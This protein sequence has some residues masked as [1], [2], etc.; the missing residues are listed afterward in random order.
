VNVSSF[1]CYQLSLVFLG[2]LRKFG[3]R[4]PA[5]TRFDSNEQYFQQRVAE[6]SQYRAL[7]KPFVSFE[8]KTVLDMGCNRGYLLHSFL[9]HEKFEAIGADLVPYYLKDARR[10]YGDTIKF[11]QTTPTTI[12]LADNSVDVVYTI[13]TVE[14]LSEPKQIF[15]EMFRVLRPGGQCLVHFNPWLHPHG[16]H[17]EDIITFPWP[18]VF[19][20]MDTLLTTAAKLYDSPAYKTSCYFKDTEGKK[21]PNPFINRDSWGTYLNYMTIKRF[22]RLLNELP[23]QVTHQERIGFGGSTFKLSRFVRGLAQV[24]VFDEFFTSVLFTVLT[25]PENAVK[26]EGNR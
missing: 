8:G 13:D 25:K 16:S 17:L 19:F 6:T 5:I 4:T 26:P 2:P 18:H 11:V 21:K 15:M 20:S 10:D 22:N 1:L 24:P 3:S 14:H 23:F 7:F 12:P 9:Q